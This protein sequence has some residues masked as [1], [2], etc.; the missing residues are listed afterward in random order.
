[1]RDRYMAEN[2]AW[3]L[4]HLGSDA[5]IV[6]AAHNGHLQRKPLTVSHGR[7]GGDRDTDHAW[8]IPGR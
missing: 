4:D 3:I 7:T 2:V 1:M 6:V 5:R 8:T